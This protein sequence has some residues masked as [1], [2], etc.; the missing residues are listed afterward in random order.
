M[1]EG[2]LRHFGGDRFE[3]ISAGITPTSLR[4]E[5]VTVMNEIGVDISG[6]Q[7]QSIDP[8]IGERFDR[9]ITVCDEAQKVC[10]TFPRAA[11]AAHWQFDDPSEAEGTEEERLAVYRRV[12]DQIRDRMRMFVLAASRADLPAPEPTSLG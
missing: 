4:P 10:P 5:A 11:E 1:A 12:R 6:H 3:A 8:Y 9:V 2:L 7:V